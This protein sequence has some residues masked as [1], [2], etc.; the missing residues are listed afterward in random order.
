MKVLGSLPSVRSASISFSAAC[1]VVCLLL[2]SIS[3]TPGLRAQGLSGISGTVT[4]P[5]GAVVPEAKVTATNTA[6]G[7]A[8]H[9]TTTSVGS[10][11][12]TDLTPGT[13]TVRVEQPGFAAAV[14]NGVTVDVSRTSTVDVALTAGTATETVEVT[15]EQITLETT[16]P[17]LGTVIENKIVQEVPVLIGGG[18]GNIGARD[19]QIDDYLFI[20]PGVQGGEFSHR[21]NGGVD[22]ENEVMFNGVVANQSE[23]QGL[24]SNI[25][26]PF[27][28]VSEI[29]VLT[30][31][32]SAQYG[33]AQ[34]V[35]SYQFASG[36]NTL[37]GD[38]FEILRNT[39]LNAAGANPPGTTSTAKGPTPTINQ[40]NYGFS[41]GGPVWIPKLYNG[42]SKT[43]FHFSADWFRQN[44][45]DSAVMTVPTQAEVGGDFSALSSP[46]FV[47]PTFVAPAGCTAPPPGTQWPGNKIPTAC[48][49]ALSK[50]LLQFVP[51]PA[52]PGL[53]NNANSLVGVLATRQTNWGFSI[54]HNLTDKQRIHG[55]Y[56]RDKY[57]NPGC[58]D[59]NAHFNSILSGKKDQPRLG[60][61]LFLT[62][63]NVFRSN[64]VMTAGFG[65]MGE[66]NNEFNSHQNVS[67]GGVGGGTVL[68]TITFNGPSGNC[69][70]NGQ[71]DPQ[72]P[73]CWGV[74]SA[75]E[76]FSINRKLGLSFDNNWL[77]TRGRHT[78]NIGW[79]IRRSYQDDHECQQCGGG[80]TFSSR[81]T[82]NPA[83][84]GTTGS[85]F[86][87][88][89]LGDADSATRK[90]ALETKLRNFYFAP[91][92]QDDI[93]LTPKM[94][95][96]VG[97]R[98]DIMRP[99]TTDSVKGQPADQIVFFNPAVPN[100]GAVSP[101]TGQ[102]LLGAASVLGTCSTCVGFSRADTKW[103]HVSPRLGIAYALNKKTELLA[104]FALNFLDGGAYEYG[105]NKLAV[106]YGNLLA[107]LTNVNSLGSNVPGYGLWDSTTLG[108]PQAAPFGPTIFNA[109]G[110]L[111]Q[112]GRD[113]GKYPYSQAWNAGIQR[114]LPYDLYVTVAYVGNR[115][116]HLPSMLNPINQT[117]PTFLSQFCPTANPTDPTC[118]M[119]PSNSAGNNV[120]TSGPA[121]LALQSAGFKQASITCP[122]SSNNPGATGTFFTP[123]TNFL[124]DY[125]SGANLS[126]ALLPNPMYNP[127]ES[128]GGLMNQF[129]TNGTAF[130]NALQVQAQK[131]YKSGLSFLVA[132]TLSKTMSNTDT[133]FATFN[134]GSEN[135]FN[136]KS[137]WSI[138]SNDQTHL[139]NITGVYELPIGPGKPLL[140]KGGYLAKNILGGWQ[141]SG[142]FQ[143]ASGSPQTVYSNNNDPFLN[144]F[145][146]ANFDP[147]VPFNLNYNNYYK[148]LPVFNQSAFS[149]PGFKAGNE[150]RVVA[151]FRN[152]F[153]ANENVGLAKQF[154]FGEHVRAELR[155]EFFNILNRMQI[156]GVGQGLDN[157]VNDG[158]TRFGII[159][160]RCQANTPRQGQ[161]FF[162]VSF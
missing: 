83:A 24:Q 43:F 63:S 149:D 3:L 159:S 111:H 53:S 30:S 16:Q 157:N 122:A 141:V 2:L 49:S 130:Y 57:A 56:W 121:Q 97:L 92:I 71:G 27:E 25:N 10:Y 152:P 103:T 127:S 34:G 8:S 87:S 144:G 51:A 98:W 153:N 70:N 1:L 105:D 85:A 23:T 48:F 120:W 33:L 64:L 74:N 4:D 21:I 124:C 93:K 80:F 65:W 17:Q 5:S 139:L 161:A 100:P 58:C 78:F 52:L 62:Y 11:I 90:F 150:P 136:Q 18:P 28:M 108:V 82:A 131:R 84:I 14:K 89:L 104:G 26:P 55:S 44:Q 143:Y 114:E 118:L 13:Y 12:I 125:G 91:Y 101:A 145:N 119:S 37:H 142:V 107:G 110:V 86:A 99:F 69:P 68:P 155:V 67:F 75:G 35:A 135:R 95:V 77:W 39:F 129:D 137:E 117:N 162:K 19:R 7:V 138:A 40:H 36:T 88:F 81:T 32:F 76:T 46:I 116:L 50:S 132:Y 148:G 38:V 96:N 94:T 134:F 15:A 72:T 9:A 115:V 146:R 160:S 128:A 20:A 151:V 133:G 66:L 60:T 6:T 47:P 106:G 147:S 61:G 109:T 123:Y 79:E 154:F 31:N 126:Q 29:Q 54:D 158:S 156:C 59:N 42:K 73:T 45:T 113:P 102:P 41:V 112:F 140:N 22:F